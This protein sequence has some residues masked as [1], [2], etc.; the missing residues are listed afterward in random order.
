MIKKIAGL[1]LALVLSACGG[2]GGSAGD[3]PFGPPP[4]TGPTLPVAASVDVIASAIQVGSG[5]DQVALTAI[6]KDANNASIAA[7]PV[8]FSVDSGNLTDQ[9]AITTAAGTAAATFTAGSNKTNRSVNVTVRSGSA[10]G[11]L[12]LQIVGTTLSYSGVTTVSL[13]GTVTVAVKAQDSR[14]VVIANLPVAVVSSLANGLSSSALTTDGQGNA[15]LSYT[16]TNAGADQLAF[17]GA[18]A[19]ARTAIQVSAANFNFVLPGAGAQIPVGTSQPITVRYLL[20]GV[21]QAGK[22]VAFAATAGTVAASALTDSAGNATVTI[23][24]A[25]ASPA[26]IQ[27]TL[28]GATE[29]AQATLAVE[30]IAITPAKLVLQVSPTAIGPNPAGASAQQAQLIATVTDANGN[31]VKNSTVNFNRVSDPSGG[32]LTQAS[33]TTDSSG[34]ASVQYIAG[35]TTTAS[36][37]VRIRATVAASTAVLGE[38]TLTVNQSSLFIALGTGNT[39]TNI[40]PETYQ[41]DWVVYVTDSNGIAVPN[42]SL[43]IKILPVQYGK[44]RLAFDGSFWDYNRAVTVFCANEDVNYN[45]VLDAGEDFNG[46]GTLEPGNVISVTARGVASGSTGIVKTD[47]TG[48]ATVSLIYAESYAPWVRVRL[49]AEALVSGTESS[50]EAVFTVIGLSTDFNTEDVAPAGLVSPFGEGSCSVPN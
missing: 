17:T 46:S 25:T 33:A 5:G 12:Q 36:N 14:G 27:A 29:A 38:A 32:N 2:G 34:Q 37:G 18:G 47:G 23:R 31:P 19:T 42:V 49:R 11:S 39:I 48:R 41:K 21:P 44:G 8:T 13:G 24:S 45:G 26:T 9:A 7:A 22:T 50:K 15:S 28:I 3:P 1:M 35:A 4:A 43:T 6:V 30:F 10:S 40:D 20:S 16:A